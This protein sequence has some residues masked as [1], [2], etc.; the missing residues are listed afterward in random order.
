MGSGVD[1]AQ[2]TTGF[3]P[4]EEQ[5]S[6]LR[7]VREW[8]KND[9]GNQSAPVVAQID[10]VAGSGKT[11]LLQTIAVM[12]NHIAPEKSKALFAFNKSAKENADQK[13]NKRYKISYKDPRYTQVYT[14]HSLGFRRLR[15]MLGVKGLKPTFEDKYFNIALRLCNKHADELQEWN[16]EKFKEPI[17]D[18]KKRAYAISTM[19]EM[20]MTSLTPLNTQ[21]VSDLIRHGNTFGYLKESKDGVSPISWF[22]NEWASNF[23]DIDH[24]SWA[25]QFE[26]VNGSV[27]FNIAIEVVKNGLKKISFENPQ[28]SEVTFSDMVFAPVYFKD[29]RVKQYG[30]EPNFTDETFDVVMI[31]ESQDTACSYYE[32][33][34]RHAHANSLVIFV[35]DKAQCINGFVGLSARQVQRIKQE[36]KARVFPV[37][38][39]QRC[40]V[41][42]TQKAAEIVPHFRTAKTTEGFTG[43]ARKQTMLDMVT[44][45]YKDKKFIGRRGSDFG[46]LVLSPTKLATVALFID[47]VMA[48]VPSVIMG[49]NDIIESFRGDLQEISSQYGNGLRSD[50]TLNHIANLQSAALSKL[51]RSAQK[52]NQET[53]PEKVKEVEEYYLSLTRFTIGAFGIV[54][55]GKGTIYDVIW[56]LGTLFEKKGK[57]SEVHEAVTVATQHKSKGLEANTVF[58]VDKQ[59]ALPE[60]HPHGSD[61]QFEQIMEKNLRYVTIT[62]S[63]NSFFDVVHDKADV[64]LIDEETEKELAQEQENKPTKLE[65]EII[66]DYARIQDKS[67]KDAVYLKTE[68]W[69][70]Q[71]LSINTSS[72]AKTKGLR[73]LSK[74]MDNAGISPSASRSAIEKLRDKTIYTQRRF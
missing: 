53:N 74:C 17:F 47:F 59:V 8:V 3:E 16:M 72:G 36:T 38:L 45:M 13:I 21:S 23:Y 5:L 34:M 11:T 44:K 18:M 29:Q 33:Y 35:G 12:L 43:Y 30:S 46:V 10:A 37:T 55:E 42:V 7:F 9:S 67:D 2:Y 56:Y 26:L 58:F 4:T 50:E 20:I 66:D 51:E 68:S 31:D 24:D 48:G 54:K 19:A 40:P 73:L 52:K 39:T 69:L 65:L 28:K 61:T 27:W 64:E 15:D 1:Y 22:G 60:S 41:K 49:A 32:L 63:K 14:A 57:G 62:R 25:K 6:V 70:N 71:F